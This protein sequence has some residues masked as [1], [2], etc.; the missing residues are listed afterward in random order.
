LPYLAYYITKKI[1][2]SKIK[3]QKT[4]NQ[5]SKI[6]NQKFKNQK[7]KI[8]LFNQTVHR[9]FV[10]CIDNNNSTYVYINS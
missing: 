1:E 9:I 3:N 8:A 7:K 4:E 10:L 5:K 2:K 6:K